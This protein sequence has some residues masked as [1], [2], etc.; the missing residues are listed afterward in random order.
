[1]DKLRVAGAVLRYQQAM[2]NINGNNVI[3]ADFGR[4]AA[5]AA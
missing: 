2:L 4:A 3:K 5:L 1:M